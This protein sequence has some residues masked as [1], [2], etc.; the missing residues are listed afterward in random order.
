MS[1][2]ST[3]IQGVETTMSNHTPA[4]EGTPT[5]FSSIIPAEYA[6]KPWV[7]DIKDTNTLFKMTDDLKS[8]LGK[9]PA[10]IP[11]ADG[12][13]TEFNKTFG[14]PESA[15]KYELG[16]A[17]NPEFNSKMR[18]IMLE[19][20]VSQRQAA[21]LDAKYNEL[22]GSMAPDT[23]AQEAEFEKLTTDTFGERKDE[24]LKTA[25]NLL[26]DNT[27]DGF[28]DRINDM[29]NTDLTILASVL[30]SIQQKYI[31]EDSLPKGSGTVATGMSADEKQLRGRSL[32]ASPAFK[33][34]GH[35]DHAKVAAEVSSLY[36]T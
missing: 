13:W 2:D 11:Q 4:A 26:L 24:V 34:K 21:I 28:S 14:V 17:S 3:E 27:P 23:A 8:E 29:S 18:D 33:D 31:S 30:D 16:E 19:A 7:Q 12:D 20:G 9:R 35:P 15:D 1:E 5:D 6:D 25:K 36:G 10:G 22:A 32:M